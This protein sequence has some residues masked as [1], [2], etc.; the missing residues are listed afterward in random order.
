MSVLDL[1]DENG[2]PEQA[3]RNSAGAIPVF[4]GIKIS[5]YTPDLIMSATGTAFALATGIKLGAGGVKVTNLGVTTEA[6]RV[7][8]GT[9]EAD[10]LLNLTIV[11]GAATT[12]DYLPSNVD[13]P[14]AGVEKY[15]A[16]KLDTH[17]AVG[18]AVAGKI[19]AVAISE[20][21]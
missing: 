1:V 11:A 4:A 10:A 8:F 18:P 7:A 21:R 9:S 19:N 16:G 20:I 5:S 13:V 6:I 17:C 3:V 12:G 15:R 2:T 14:G